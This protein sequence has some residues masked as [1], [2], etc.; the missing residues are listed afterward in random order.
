MIWKYLSVYTD[1]VC[2]ST[3]SYTKTGM[4]Y[5]NLDSTATTYAEEM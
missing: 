1:T 4:T 5:T 2:H 3:H